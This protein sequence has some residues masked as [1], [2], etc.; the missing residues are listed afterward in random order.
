MVV[1]RHVVVVGVGVVVGA[2]MAVGR[3]L[4]VVCVGAALMSLWL[5]WD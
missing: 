3:G 5:A 1:G 2:V 4:I